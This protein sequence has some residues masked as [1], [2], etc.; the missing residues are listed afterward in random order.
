MKKIINGFRYDTDKAIL[1]GEYYTPGIG[2]ND[3]HYWEAALYKTPKAGRFFL[4]GEGQAM[5]SFASHSGNSSGWG[6]DLIPMSK[7]EALEWAEQY[8]DADIIEEHFADDIQEA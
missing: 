4:A 7:G 3:F 5:T 8:L 1:I 2:S 6:E